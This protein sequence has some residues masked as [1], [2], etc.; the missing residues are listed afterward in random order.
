[1]KTELEQWREQM[2]KQQIQKLSRDKANEFTVGILAAGIGV[3]TYSSVRTGFRPIWMTEVDEDAIR[4]WKDLYGG[5]CLGDTFQ[6]DY[7][8]VEVPVYLTSG[9]PC[10]NYARSGD[11]SGRFGS[12]GWMFMEQVKVILKL[13]PLAIRLEISDYAW[14]VN[15]GA[16]VK[17]VLKRLR[18]YYSIKHKIVEVWDY[19]D[20]SCRRRLIIVGFSK[21]LGS[22]AEMFEFPAAQYDNNHWHCAR[23]VAIGD[24][25]VPE[26]YW[27]YDN[28][29]R[30]TNDERCAFE[31]K[32]LRKLAQSGDGIGPSNCPNSRYSWDGPFNGQT[33]VNGGGQRPRLDWKDTGDN[34]IGA[35]RLTV[36]EEAISVASLPHWF[37]EVIEEVNGDSRFLFRSV[38]NG[39]PARTSTA[40]DLSVMNVLQMAKAKLQECDLARKVYA[41]V[42]RQV[43]R[44][45][46]NAF[47]V[48]VKRKRSAMVDTGA[49]QSMFH[50]DVEGY[51]KKAK[52]SNMKIQVASGGSMNG[53]VDGE[54][55]MKTGGASMK[56]QGTTVDGLPMELISVDQKYY[57]E[58]CNLLL[59]QEDFKV[60][61]DKCGHLTGVGESRITKRHK[62]AEVSVPVRADALKGG[63]W[64]DYELTQESDEC[65]DWLD[66]DVY[67]HQQSFVMASRAAMHA[68]VTEVVFGDESEPCNIRGVKSGL[69]PSKQRMTAAEFHDEYIHLGTCPVPCEICKLTKGTMRRITRIVDR[70]KESRRAHTFVMDT[71]TL[72]RRSLC[73]C[74]YAIIIKCVA[75][76]YYHAIFL[77]K[78]SDS[79]AAIKQ[80][81]EALR[82]DP[83]FQNMVYKPVQKIIADSAGEWSMKCAEYLKMQKVMEFT[84]Q[85][86]C[87]DRKEEAATAERAVAVV[88]VP[89]KAGLMMPNL[90]PSWWVRTMKQAI[91]LL[92]RFGK[93]VTEEYI[94]SDGD[95]PRPLERFT[96]Y[97]YSRRQI[98]RELSYFVPVGRPT[99]VHLTQ[100]KGSAITPKS[101]WAVPIGMYREQVIFW[102]PFSKSEFRSKSFTAYKLQHG[103]NYM[104]FLNLPVQLGSQGK[105]AMAV[106]ME[107]HV[108]IMLP[109]MRLDAREQPNRLNTFVKSMKHA[110]DDADKCSQQSEVA[111]ASH[112]GCG[113]EQ[114]DQL[115]GGF[116][117]PVPSVTVR[118]PSQK[119]GGSVVIYDHEGNPID[120][121][122]NTGELL[123][124]VTT[125]AAPVEIG[126]DLAQ[127]KSNWQSV[128]AKLLNT[129]ERPTQQFRNLNS[130]IPNAQE[131]VH[132]AIS[133]SN[134]MWDAAEAKKHQSKL[135][136]TGIGDSFVQV[137]KKHKI[138]FEYHAAYQQWIVAT[139]KSPDG[140]N[141][142]LADVPM[143][144]TK[145]RPEMKMPWPSGSVWRKL[146]ADSNQKEANDKHLAMNAMLMV[147]EEL[148]AN[149]Q[150]IRKSGRVNFAKIKANRRLNIQ[151]SA[152]AAR[153]KKKASKKPW[154]EVVKLHLLL[155]G[156]V[157]RAKEGTSGS[158]LLRMK[159]AV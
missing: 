62:G 120:L 94:A 95:Q 39:I 109:E 29:E 143:D 4:I 91:W 96:G 37:Q 110:I 157:L 80:W 98:D 130:T 116:V 122:P 137:C 142:K 60:E 51:M 105:D 11:H 134:E 78:K 84:T 42:A 30:V 18:E 114:V 23:D 118:E 152:M 156:A 125:L 12:T 139:Q 43:Q 33:A 38:N 155:Q 115:G 6:V 48:R 77:V 66:D 68:A 9:Q 55:K 73:K 63:F 2:T 61:C 47:R 123:D 145:L 81:I 57:E 141:L 100:V 16:E 113:S 14:Q 148:K 65:D 22:V 52:R 151:H 19:G 46:A 64:V 112:K 50:R 101:R 153:K 128:K 103:M 5:K 7:S 35:T 102:S 85:W 28:P 147:V 90:P 71:V 121:D 76:G 107:D 15:D 104:H 20:V 89:T 34:D 58:R 108:S 158:V 97:Q 135:I 10:P 1:M 106:T 67:D 99:L 27:R 53:A 56:L 133:P 41:A 149:D 138:Q 127:G 3:C 54:V 70:Y 13:M 17:Y 31:H 72:N 126:N 88:E 92:N 119:L 87:P 144:R 26:Q 146:K 129:Q 36:L 132:I 40:I 49:N 150:E 117:M 74:Q 75:T 25:K 24:D 140:S 79:A 44:A 8:E 154:L 124:S 83:M 21:Q 93:I 111:T 69:K 131:Y 45:A 159:S 59:L 82:A 86:G 136:M 32:R